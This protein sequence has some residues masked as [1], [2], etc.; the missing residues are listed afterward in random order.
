MNI[1]GRWMLIQIAGP[2][3]LQAETAAELDALLPAILPPA[4]SFGGT[5]DRAFKGEMEL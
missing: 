2:K 5:G 3:H 1:R 4:P